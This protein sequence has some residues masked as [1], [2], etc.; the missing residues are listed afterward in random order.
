MST[1]VELPEDQLAA[2]ASLCEREGIS[3]DEAVQRA[4]TDFLTRRTEN[5]PRDPAFGSWAGRKV[6]SVEYVRQLRAEW[7]R[8]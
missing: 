8:A 3:R 1:V 4:L 7:D 5:F 6:D 2:L